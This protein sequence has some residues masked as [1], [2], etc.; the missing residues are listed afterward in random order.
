MGRGRGGEVD[1]SLLC[2]LQLNLNQSAHSQRARLG[3]HDWGG[4]SY[5][6]PIL[7]ATSVAAAVERFPM[8]QQQ[9]TKEQ[10]AACISLLALPLCFVDGGTTTT[11]RWQRR[12][13]ALFRLA[14]F[15][16]HIPPNLQEP[17]Q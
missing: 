7:G 6:H 8:M 9:R 13:F 11:V 17:A 14:P 2:L 4:S 3:I 10:E 16:L 1:S 5:I 12:R 15:D